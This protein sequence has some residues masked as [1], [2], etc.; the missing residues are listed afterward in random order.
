MDYIR[1]LESVQEKTK[2]VN[3]EILLIDNKSSRIKLQDTIVKNRLLK[4]GNKLFMTLYYGHC[5]GAF[6]PNLSIN[7]LNH[8]F[9]ITI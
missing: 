3:L 2:F 8:H 5:T 9:M 7:F 6:T 4:L 1:A